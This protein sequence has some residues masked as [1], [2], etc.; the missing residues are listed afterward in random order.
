MDSRVSHR[1]R[2]R[3]N[4]ALR[5]QCPEEVPAGNYKEKQAADLK[6]SIGFY[7]GI[8]V[9]KLQHILSAASHAFRHILPAAAAAAVG[10]ST[11]FILERRSSRSRRPRRGGGG[12]RVKMTEE[13]IARRHK[14]MEAETVRRIARVCTTPQ[15]K[16]EN[17]T[18]VGRQRQWK[19]KLDTVYEKKG[20][21][22]RKAKSNVV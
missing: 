21:R 2:S 11:R 15:L 19:P 7:D 8:A 9:E 5:R 10:P 1:K 14:E 6:A 17:E 16:K 18:L 3:R 4:C 20:L 22:P 13:M 12:L